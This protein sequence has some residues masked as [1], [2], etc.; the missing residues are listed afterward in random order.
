MRRS[1]IRPAR[2][3]GTPARRMCAVLCALVA[4]YCLVSPA[5]AAQ[6]LGVHVARRGTTFVIGI[7]VRIDAPPPDV[8]A[9]LRD[10][11]AL[12]RYDTALRRVHVEPTAD[13]NR[14]RLFATVHACVLIFC[15]TMHQEQIMTAVPDA[16]GGELRAVLVSTG[17][18]FHGGHAR[19]TVRPCSAGSA[20]SC[21]HA[22]IE[23]RPDF[24]VP[25]LIGPWI[26]KR[27]MVDEAHEYANGLE[28]IARHLHGVGT[29]SN[30]TPSVH[31][32]R[33]VDP[34]TP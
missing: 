12:P 29:R 19:W 4:L 20:L 26:L 8:F 5:R 3:F 9:A 23:L 10:Y 24:W 14:V 30:R 15:K 11:A 6:V 18:D 34:H 1:S 21:L 2:I 28:H 31:H 17:G 22:R 32:P 27:K 16:D 33:R 7:R 25:P 13:A